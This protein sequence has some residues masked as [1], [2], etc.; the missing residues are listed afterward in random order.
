[1][2]IVWKAE[3]A[4]SR[5]RSLWAVFHFHVGSSCIGR[6]KRLTADVVGHG[7]R[8]RRK[9]AE[10]GDARMELSTVSCLVNAFRHERLSQM[11]EQDINLYKFVVGATRISQLKSMQLPISHR[12]LRELYT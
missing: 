5:K 3:I 4:H 6:L 8:Q 7:G 12:Y 9:L 10:R 11:H 1:M 2:S